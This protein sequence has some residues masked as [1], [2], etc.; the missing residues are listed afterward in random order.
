MK[1]FLGILHDSGL[2][3]LKKEGLWSL[4]S[5]DREGTEGYL[6]DLVQ[7]AVKALEGNKQAALDRER[8]NK[9]ERVGPGCAERM[10]KEKST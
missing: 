7:A 5:I 10:R 8:L 3:R 9:A 1:V 2:I 6:E 4:Y